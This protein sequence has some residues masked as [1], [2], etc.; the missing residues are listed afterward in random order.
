MV[1]E[2]TVE[3]T[4]DEVKPGDWL[5]P[6]EGVPPLAPDVDVTPVTVPVPTGLAL[7]AV[8]IALGET[9]GVAIAATWDAGRADLVHEVQYRPSAGGDWVAMA[10]DEDMNTARSGPVDSGTE[11]EVRIR[12]LTI[13]YRTSDWS[14]VETITPVATSALSAPSELAAEGGA[15]EATIS[16]RLPVQAS[17]AYAR[18]FGSDSDDFGTAV[19]IG[20]D[21]VGGLGAV[22]TV[23]D[24]GLSAGT[25]YYWARAFKASGE[26]SPAAGSVSAIVS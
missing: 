19:Q 21:I 23:T 3:A 2:N 5:P 25:R 1:I 4:L 12:A 26:A 15:G 7:S 13:G 8:Q 6:P 14:A 18:A 24:S 10:T 9:N 11:Y 22:V 16:F 17:L 20:P